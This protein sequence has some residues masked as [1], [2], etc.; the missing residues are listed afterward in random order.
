MTVPARE[1]TGGRAAGELRPCWIDPFPVE[2]AEGSAMIACG[3][4]RVLCTATIE[5]GV[6]RFLEGAGRGWLTAEYSML[7]RATHTRTPR[8]AATGKVQG[9]AQE[10]PQLIGRS[11]GAA[12]QFGA[13][14]DHTVL[15]RGVEESFVAL[16]HRYRSPAGPFPIS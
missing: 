3:K 16:R 12:V 6:P 11:L 8:G 1:R 2:F 15:G 14:G 7:P 4:T 5:A 13:L 10:I 9:R